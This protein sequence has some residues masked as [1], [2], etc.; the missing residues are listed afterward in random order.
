MVI[1]Y[2]NQVK[3]REGDRSAANIIYVR[4]TRKQQ[5]NNWETANRPY[6]Y[7]TQQNSICPNATNSKNKV[8]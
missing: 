5:T 6:T 4:A 7:T 3:K 8:T 2:T 1:D